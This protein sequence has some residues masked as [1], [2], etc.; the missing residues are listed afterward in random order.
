MGYRSFI[1]DRTGQDGVLPSGTGQGG[2]P[3]P[4]PSGTGYAWTG[5]GAGGTPLAVSR[6]R[7]FF[8]FLVVKLSFYDIV[9]DEIHAK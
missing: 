6:R 5:Y 1:W 3:S 2:V 4:P 9:H 7:T 8:L